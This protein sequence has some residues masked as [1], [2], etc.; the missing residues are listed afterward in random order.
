[1]KLTE[2][3]NEKQQNSDHS[4]DPHGSEQRIKGMVRSFKR[5]DFS[6]EVAVQ[7]LMACYGLSYSD[8]K[9]R[10]DLYW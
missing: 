7:N 1:M 4:L 8:A 6:R 5:L 3:N 10:V 9:E 2:A